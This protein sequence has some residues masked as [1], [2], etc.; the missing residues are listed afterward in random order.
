MIRQVTGLILIAIGVLLPGGLEAQGGPPG[1]RQR[2]QLERRLEMGFARI[3]QNRLGLTAEEM[4]EVQSVMQSFR[5]DR[6]E[7]NRAQASLRYRL[8][9]PGLEQASDQASRDLLAEMI[10]VQ[11]AELDLYRREQQELLTVLTPNQVVRFYGLRE[12]WGRRIQELRQPGGSRGPGAGRGP[13]GGAPGTGGGV[14][15]GVPG[16]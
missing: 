13:G 10:R 4:A 5:S 12:E 14:P 1:G 3:V 2:Q 15:G 6:Q 16:F 9:D 7:I 11:E 8:R